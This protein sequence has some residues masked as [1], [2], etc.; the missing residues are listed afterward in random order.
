[1]ELLFGFF[2]FFFNFLKFLKI[3]KSGPS[4]EFFK[5]SSHLALIVTVRRQG[6]LPVASVSPTYKWAIIRQAWIG[7]MEPQEDRSPPPPMDHMP[8]LTEAAECSEGFELHVTHFWV[9][10]AFITKAVDASVA[11]GHKAWHSLPLLPF[12]QISLTDDVRQ[13]L[14]EG[15]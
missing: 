7:G 1:M 10:S 12:P 5:K 15:L 2:F 11:A 4:S 6:L 8:I 9:I 14:K 3:L 13:T